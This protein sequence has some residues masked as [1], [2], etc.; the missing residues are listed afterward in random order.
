MSTNKIPLDINERISAAIAKQKW[1]LLWLGSTLV[2]ILLIASVIG[3]F[4]YNIFKKTTAL[5]NVTNQT[6]I[7]K[8]GLEIGEINTEPL[9]QAQVIV[10]KKDIEY[11]LPEKIRNAFVYDSYFYTVKTPAAATSTITATTTKNQ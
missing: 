3:F 5:F 7:D 2:F 1:Y 4:A 6:I 8:A 10:E 9:H 11:A